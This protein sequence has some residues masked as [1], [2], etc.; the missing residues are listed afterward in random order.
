[1]VGA[2]MSVMMPGSTPVKPFS[3]TPTIWSGFSRIVTQRPRTSGFLPNRR[4]PEVVAQHGHRMLTRASRHRTASAACPTPASRR[5]WRVRLRKSTAH[6]PSPAVRAV[7]ERR[8]APRL[9]A[10]ARRAARSGRPASRMLAKERVVEAEPIAG[11]RRC[12]Q[13]DVDQRLRI[14]HRQR[15]QDQRIDQREGSGAGADRQRERDDGR[16]CDD[17]VPSAEPETEVDIPQDRLEPRKQLDIAARLA[18]EER[19]A[20]LG[21]SL[22]SPSL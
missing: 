20:E 10:H 15:P 9:V 14:V 4:D 22:A 1:M 2:Q 12:A 16:R 21:Q 11:V 13:G 7:V 5:E 8:V 19:V 18:Q 3:A 6:R 17:L